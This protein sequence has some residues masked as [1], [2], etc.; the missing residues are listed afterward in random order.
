MDSKTAKGVSRADDAALE[1]LEETVAVGWVESFIY[2]L[3]ANVLLARLFDGKEEF[4][5]GLVKLFQSPV[6]AGPFG[7]A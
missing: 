6:V 5:V 2:D 1:P 4:A 7:I 3:D